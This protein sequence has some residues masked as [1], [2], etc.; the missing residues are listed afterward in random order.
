MATVRR[1]SLCLFCDVQFKRLKEV[2]KRTFP[3][4]ILARLINSNKEKNI[5]YLSGREVMNWM[6]INTDA[7][8]IEKICHGAVPGPNDDLHSRNNN[9]N[10]N[11]NNNSNSSSNNNNNNSNNNI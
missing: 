10:N 4:R 8:K 5:S 9:N 11:N 1:V 6:A 2:S 3:R 7:K